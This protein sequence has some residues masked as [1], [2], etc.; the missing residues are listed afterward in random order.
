[1]AKSSMR[2]WRR[3]SGN[4][5]PI[6]SP[7][8]APNLRRPTPWRDVILYLALLTTLGLAMLLFFGLSWALPLA[9]AP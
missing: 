9:P 5:L 6:K 1:M 7:A 2:R 8:T 4:G 3:H